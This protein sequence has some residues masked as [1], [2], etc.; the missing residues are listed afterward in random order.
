MHPKPDAHSY[1]INHSIPDL[2]P[3]TS[4]G[5]RSGDDGGVTLAKVWK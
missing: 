2:S 5:A 3:G 4:I 1:N